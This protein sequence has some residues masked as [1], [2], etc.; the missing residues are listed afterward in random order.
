MA[1][2]DWVN[3]DENWQDI[4]SNTTTTPSSPMDAFR[5]YINTAPRR[6]EQGIANRSSI[7]ANLIQD[8]TTISRFLQH[9]LGT[10]LRTLG[11]AGELAEG[12]PA[13]IALKLNKPSQIIPDIQ[14]TLMGERPAQYGDI[15]RQGGVPE[16]LAAVGGLLATGIKG[17]P[18]AGLGEVVSKIISPATQTLKYVINKFGKPAVAQSM[19]FLTGGTISP[20]FAQRALD[21]PDILSPKL[22]AQQGSMVKQA[23]DT[24]IEP[25]R[26]NPEALVDLSSVYK[27][28]E[29]EGLVVT[30]NR[31]PS[32]FYTMKQS[33]VG[34]I[35]GLVKK[36]NLYG[37][38]KVKVD[39]NETEGLINQ[40]D[41]ALGKYYSKQ[42]KGMMTGKELPSTNF[43]RIAN[44]IRNKLST[45]LKVQYPD[46][47][48]VIEL[49]Q[50]HIL[51]REAANSFT[52]I[53]ASFFKSIV[54]RMMMIGAGVPTGGAS[55]LAYPLTMPVAWK[56]IIRGGQTIGQN[57]KPPYL[58]PLLRKGLEKG[59]EGDW[60]DVQ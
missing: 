44:I 30:N 38:G 35:N 10:S 24:V 37:R 13:D 55:L 34:F 60:V 32:Q 25:L 23:Y 17:T 15:L 58:M 21:N 28:L 5:Q 6:V 39:F 7:I 45:A 8:P 51:N 3:V 1:N 53:N 18:T 9:P 14:K 4:G 36:L 11:G 48:P 50:Q 42:A 52:G 20:Q 26:K 16:P 31:I 41:E 27:T 49:A 46:V 19:R 54:P 29:Q 12:I 33:E 43:E 2:N 59:N 57:I 47:A 40:I 56:G 22:M